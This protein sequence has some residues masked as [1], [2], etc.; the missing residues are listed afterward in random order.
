M[1]YCQRRSGLRRGYGGHVDGGSCDGE[2]SPASAEAVADFAAA[3]RGR[4]VE[5][6]DGGGEV[7]GLGLEGNYGFERALLE[8]VG[9]VGVDGGELAHAGPLYEGHVVLIGGDEAVGVL[10][11]G[12][13]DE[14]EEGEVFFLAV[15]DEAAVENLVAA[16]LGVD[17]GETEYFGVGEG[18]SEPRGESAEV[19][20]FLGAQGQTLLAVVVGNV[21]DVDNVLGSGSDVENRGREAVGVEALEHGVESGVGA[22]G[23]ERE[24]LDTRNAGETHV[25]SDLYG[26]RA[27]G[28]NHFFTGS[29]V[30]AGNVCRRCRTGS[31]EEPSQFFFLYGVEAVVG[32]HGINRR[33]AFLEEYYHII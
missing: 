25:L 12:A 7:V 5:W 1:A 23:D 19:F 15:D 22:L 6:L 10:L 13:L 31:V 8:V 28:G 24:L 4:A 3:A 9:A 2:A 17:L 14:L 27:P 32:A 21:V 33:R 30:A 20:F 16:V 26:I 18:S 29:D 11:R